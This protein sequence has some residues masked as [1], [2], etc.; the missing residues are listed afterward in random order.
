MSTISDVSKPW[1]ALAMLPGVGGATL[2]KLHLSNRW[3]GSTDGLWELGH[4]LGLPR[5]LKAI[6]EHEALKKAEKEAV[7]QVKMAMRYNSRIITMLDEDFPQLLAGSRFNPFILYV[8]GKLH[9]EP[10]KSVAIIGTRKPTSRGKLAAQELARDASRSGWSVVSGLALGCDTLAH[11]GA[12]EVG[13]H[14]VAV[15][16][17]GLHTVAPETNRRLAEEIVEAGGAL[18]SHYP[19]GVDPEP[20][21]FVQRDAI[22]SGLAQGVCLVQSNIGGGSLH[23]CRAGI[24]DKRWVWV[25]PPSPQDVRDD[26]SSIQANLALLRGSQQDKLK[27]LRFKPEDD[28][29]SLLGASE[30]WPVMAGGDTQEDKPDEMLGKPKP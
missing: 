4:D 18:V 17:H 22:Q 5:L 2:K 27:T 14:T 15:L 9:S 26:R 23:A 25:C 3:D 12:I 8:R 13:G 30:P 6:D 11:R 29:S 20:R 10:E 21:Q 16:A 28:I 24:M 1:L 7:R 19:F